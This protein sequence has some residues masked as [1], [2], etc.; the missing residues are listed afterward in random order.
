MLNKP[1]YQR[2]IFLALC[3]VPPLLLYAVFYIYP[4]IY[5]FFISLF[6][7]SGYSKNM[8]FVGLKNFARLLDDPIVL[9]GIKNNLFFLVWSTLVIFILSMFFAVCITRLR[10]RNPG[11][12]R[13]VFFFPNVL[14]IIVVGVLWMFIYNPS[15]GM[16]NSILEG[17]GLGMLIRDWLGDRNVVMSALVVPQAWMYIGFYMV[18]FIAAIQGIPE[19]YFESAVIDGANQ[20]R[21]QFHIT[22]P[23]I[24]GTLRTA[25]VFFVVN[26]FSRTF[27]LVYVVTKGGPN[28]ASELLTTYLYEQAF[29]NGKFGY[30]TAIGLVLFV[31]VCIISFL[32]LKLTQR[33]IIEF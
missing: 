24:W 8:T 33:E 17:T 22:F 30:G 7:W 16:L 9:V 2:N 27:A 19:E 4:F 14:S 13:I 31:V 25:L 23:L 10:I 11:F 28:R 15:F 1:T 3:I 12:F 29:M 20:F 6:D 26:A 5:A 32:V 18:L 21:Q